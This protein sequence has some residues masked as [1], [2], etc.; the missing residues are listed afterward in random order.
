MRYVRLFVIG[1]L[2]AAGARAQAIDPSLYSDI[3]WRSVGPFRGGW[4]TCAEGAPDAPETYYFGAAAGGV[5]KTDSAGRTWIPVFDR[6]GSASIG[7]I[8]VAPSNKDVVWVGTGQ[9]QARY[10]IA[11]GDGVYRSDDAGQTWRHAGLEATRAIGRILVDP[12]NPDVAVVAALG[13]IYGA[14]KERGIYRT[15]DGGRTWNQTLFVADDTGA[16]D[17]ARDPEHPDVLYASLWQGRNYPWLSYF[18]PMAGPRSGIY[19]SEDAGRTWKRLSGGGWPQS[20]LGRIG[21]AAAAGKRVWALVDAPGEMGA[22]GAEGARSDAGL[23][24]SDDAGATWQRVN[25]TPGLASSY[26][27]RVA[28]DPKQRDAVYITGQSIRRSE[29]GGKTLTWFRGAPGGD[30]YHFVWINPKRPEYMIT[31]ADQGTIVSVDGGKTWSDWYNQPTGQFYHVETDDRFPYW[32]YGGQQ[33]SGTAGTASRSDYGSITFRDWNP[34]G[35]EERGWDVP[36][37]RDPNVVYGTGLGGTVTRW[38]ARTAQV[39][40]VSPSTESTYGR[41][42]TP[43]SYRWGWAFPLAIGRKAPNAVYLG[44]QYLLR[45]LDG[46]GS[47]EKASPDLTGADENAKGCPTTGSPSLDDAKRC[48]Y[49]VIWSIEIS[50]RDDAEIW[51]GTDSGVVSLTRDA[52]KTWKDVSPKGMPAWTKIASVDVSPLEPGVAY[53]AADRHRAD[54][55]TPHVYRTRDYGASWQEVS[56]GLP[57]S[58]FVTVVRADTVRRGLLYAGTD[59]G[60]FV[61]FDD[62]GHWQP[63]QSGL[64]T[65][66]IGDLQVHGTDLVAATQGRAF[67]VLDDVTPLRH[68]SQNAASAA[69]TLVPPAAAVRLRANMNRDT[70]LP[71]EVPAASNPPAGAVLDYVLGR[72]AKSVRLEILDAKKEVVR[73][74]SSDAPEP[75]PKARQYFTDRYIHP[76]GPPPTA[77]GHHRYLWDLRYPRP[78]SDQYEYV[79]AA[80][81]GENT[82]VDPRGPLALPGRYTVR[83]TVDGA[84]QEQ[85]LEITMDPRV[86]VD[87]GV[88]AS[89]LEL[90]R[91]VSAT[92]TASYDALAKVRGLRKSIAA[93]KEKAAAGAKQA[94]DDVD[95]RAKRIESGEAGGGGGR[96]RAGGGLAGVNARLGGILNA[97]DGADAPPTAAERE[98]AAH[99]RQEADALVAQWHEL[100]KSLPKGVAAIRL[101]PADGDSESPSGV[102]IE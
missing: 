10:D 21:L 55:F 11:S 17:L 92:M 76:Q 101:N 62:G 43:G 40:N 99:L 73:S 54:D 70:P 42:P 59:G 85:P 75:A 90:Q 88:L 30:D 98:S 64:P 27:N 57:A 31:A 52:G 74:Y 96:R 1:V 45:S 35:G 58:R 72:A 65:A 94:L 91:Q 41:R 2:A 22:P 50:P 84:S 86:K 14:N 51:T 82:P 4:A 5:W 39:R 3:H 34:V 24:R 23:Y 78:A 60:A 13:H 19:K 7:A 15:E 28:A 79:I 6:E 95:A 47:W 20:S 12:A 18:E 44:S 66:W 38:D 61:S 67:W 77:A 81:A 53:I 71:P 69:A 46:G 80:I 8:A 48:G 102:E 87:A 63:L 16:A 93:A 68:L 37:P 56:E 36:D 89:A 83:L 97:M 32:I 100:E 9:I 33:D 49:G 29:D 26:A 25:A